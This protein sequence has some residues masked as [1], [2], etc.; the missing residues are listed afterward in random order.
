MLRKT[1]SQNILNLFTMPEEPDKVAEFTETK[2]ISDKVSEGRLRVTSKQNI[3][4]N[5]FGLGELAENVAIAQKVSKAQ[6]NENRN[7]KEHLAILSE[8]QKS[9]SLSGFNPMTSNGSS[10][11]SANAGGITD[12]G[13][14]QKQ[15]KIPTSNS[16]FNPD[17]NAIEASKIDS[18]TE[19]KIEKEKI[20]TNRRLSEQ[21]RMDDMV[22]SL[23]TTNQSKSSSAHR[24]G[25]GDL[26]RTDFKLSRNNISIFDSG[27]FDR[28]PEKTRGE[29]VSEQVAEKNAQIDESWR[30][31]GKSLKSR[32]VTNRFFDSLIEKLESD[33]C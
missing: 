13:G 11:I 24:T 7:S 12:M 22:E 27:D 21:K 5:F 8:E 18:K 15:I 31:N 33:G 14:P 20:A 19:T 32:E 9:K 25:T 1:K 28:V 10:I 29:K 23:R 4:E 2:N 16:I 3:S 26:E 30:Q 17:R 6:D